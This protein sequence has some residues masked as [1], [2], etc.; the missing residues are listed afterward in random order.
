MYWKR[1]LH[2]FGVANF[3]FLA[4]GLQTMKFS[5]AIK[6]GHE[7]GYGETHHSYRGCA[8]GTAY[9]YRTGKILSHS[10]RPLFIANSHGEAREVLREEVAKVFGIPLETVK[11]ADYKHQQGHSRMWIA[12]EL[13]EQGY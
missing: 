6:G 10:I 3:S 8:I 1:F 7:L 5:E 9:R 12:Q 4:P 2:D 11:W 13:E